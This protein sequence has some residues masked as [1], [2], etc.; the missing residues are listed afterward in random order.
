VSYN[1]VTYP[2]GQ[3]VTTDS[4][5][6]S[7]TQGR[8]TL[9]PAIDYVIPLGVSLLDVLL[10]GDGGNGGYAFDDIT[11]V[12]TGGGGSAGDVKRRSVALTSTIQYTVRFTRDGLGNSVFTLVSTPTTFTSN[13]GLNGFDAVT[14]VPGVGGN[15]GLV[16]GPLNYS[17]GGV[18]PLTPSGV[19]GPGLGGDGS[20]N[21]TN[22]PTSV[23]G[24][25]GTC[26]VAWGT[27]VSTTIAYGDTAGTAGYNGRTVS[28]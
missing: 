19:V 5:S 24:V 26:V 21:P 8:I 25:A 23:L 16:S 7:V 17:D 18:N 12:Q 11:N 28:V 2:D 13:K 6:S 4:G 9:Q 3:L 10:V 15:G 22:S 14:G 20:R 1:E 27:S